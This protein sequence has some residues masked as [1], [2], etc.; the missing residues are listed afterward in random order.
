MAIF[1]HS[2]SKHM[3]GH[4]KFHDDAKHTEDSAI[5]RVSLKN[6]SQRSKVE[7]MYPIKDNVLAQGS[8]SEVPDLVAQM[9]AFFS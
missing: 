6:A 8:L 9:E 4:D 5:R 2:G 7:T 1:I 3:F